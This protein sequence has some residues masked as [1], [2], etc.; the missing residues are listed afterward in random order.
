MVCSVRGGGAGLL[1]E[2]IMTMPLCS[3]AES[4]RLV[5]RCCT[6]SC[7]HMAQIVRALLITALT[8]RRPKPHRYNKHI[9]LQPYA[10]CG[11]TRNWV[12]SVVA[13]ILFIIAR[14]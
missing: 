4:Q 11:G 5:W 12:R 3:Q 8:K 10:T 14:Q 2:C 13:I 6:C 9:R 7:M 1:A